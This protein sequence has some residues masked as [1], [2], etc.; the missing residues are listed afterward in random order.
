M[1]GEPGTGARQRRDSLPG[2]PAATAR[3]A[4]RRH[5]VG[6]YGTIV[7]AGVL[8]S[9]GDE[10]S[11]LDLTIAVLITLVVYWLAEEYAEILGEHLAGGRL[12]TWRYALAALAATWPMVGASFLPLLLVVLCWLL[13]AAPSAAANVGLIAAV[14]ELMLYA[15]AAGRAAAL[16]R[17]Q[18]LTLAAAAAVLGLVMVFLKDV[19][20]VQLH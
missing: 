8:A 4:G 15:W 20:L 5:A 11:S 3:P 2:R 10:V 13:G 16:P 18:Q 19:I 14:G 12:P 6:I 7:T 1:T 9:A 17:R